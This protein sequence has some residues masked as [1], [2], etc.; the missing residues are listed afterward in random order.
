M[1]PWVATLDLHG[2]IAQQTRTAWHI[3]ASY[4]E[5]E[6][7]AQE[8]MTEVDPSGGGE[9]LRGSSNRRKTDHWGKERQLD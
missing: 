1:S 7:L 5:R 9:D 2:S 8:K 6:A 4:A 3:L